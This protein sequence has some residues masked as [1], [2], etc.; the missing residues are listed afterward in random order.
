VPHHRHE[1]VDGNTPIPPLFLDQG[2][3]LL[4]LSKDE[5]SWLDPRT[6][7]LLRTLRLLQPGQEGY[8]SASSISASAL[9]GDGKHLVLASRSYRSSVRIYD[10]A[11]A[12]PV[13]PNLEHRVM[14][15]V[16]A[17]AF[18]A[19]GKMLLTGSGDR[20]A[21]LW[22]VP[23][24]KP[25][26]G[27][28]AHPAQVTSVAFAP[29]GHHLATAQR[30]GL[31]RLWA[32]PAGNP[33]DYRVPVGAWSFVRLSRDG[34][35]LL[36]TGLSTNLSESCKLR[37]TQVFDLTAGQPVEP[38]LEADGIILDAAFSPDGLQ[39]AC[40]VSRAAFPQE[41]TSQMVQQPGQLLLWDRR[42]GKL[43]HQPLQLPSEPRKLD[44]SPD[45]GQLAV[46][47]AK[48]ELVVIDPATGKML[49]APWRAHPPAL[50]TGSWTN[51]GAVRFS[52]DGRRLLTFGTDTKA[53]VWD[54]LTGQL[55]HEFE[56]QGTCR[57]AQFSPDGRL[58]ATAGYDNRVGVWELATGARLASLAHPDI[59]H[60]APFSPDGQH[61][62]TACRD[63]MARLW[64]WR[65][66][67]LVCPPFEHEHEVHA[68]AFMPDGRHVL[69]ASD[70]E[71]LKI[72]EWRTGKP[73]CPPLA[74]G[75]VG[76]S[77]AVTPD[78]RRV[79][80][81]GFMKEL[82]VFH[83]DDWLVPS[84]LEPDDLCAWGEIVSGQRIED[85]GGVTNLTAE[86][87]QERWQAFR[88]RHPDW[89]TLAPPKGAVRSGRG[90]DPSP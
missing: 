75:G 37:H 53:R 15:G 38:P 1:R 89:G 25:L 47:C 22:S 16:I 41:R 54:A 78:G 66:G 9:S 14:Q 12:R 62:L 35:F 88:R 33:R 86:Q 57:D 83:L 3:G 60:T 21:R 81:G 26:G 48:G 80:C 19:D 67:R 73:V 82:R 30:G 64:D 68:V 79:A 13:S 72:W 8:I 45:G 61:L 18:S 31:I 23:A 84:A 50:G 65:A 63:G 7:R 56:H 71:V 46:I 52:P 87:W 85:G 59:T 51:N 77:L 76:L 27:P 5:A 42:V 20:T 70:D 17:A 90:R 36:P 74:L 39:V 34:R 29:D 44:Y 28:L 2:R 6:G 58:V 69:S 32:L 55:Q 24:G 4:T 43:Q 40:A 11:S 49:R 10:V